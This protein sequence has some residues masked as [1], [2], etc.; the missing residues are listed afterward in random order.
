MPTIGLLDNFNRANSA[1]LNNGT[2]WSQAVVFANAGIRV[3]TNQAFCAPGLTALLCL[4]PAVWN[5]PAAG[6]AARQGAA[7]TFASTP[8]T[9]TALV[10]KAGTGTTPTNYLRVRYSSASGGQVVVET[11]TTG[12]AFTTQATFPGSFAVGD[13]LSAIALADGTVVAYRTSGATTTQLGAMT[14]ATSGTGSWAPATGSGRVGMQLPS[15]ARLDNFSGG[16]L[17]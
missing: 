11:T 2:N 17:P 10:L 6:F 5:A 3:N 7:L 16:T 14:V 9:G 4:V 8:T 1:T 15:G 12:T 13:V